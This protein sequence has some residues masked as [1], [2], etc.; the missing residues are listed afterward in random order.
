MKQLRQDAHEMS[1][2]SEL[3]HEPKEEDKGETERT[4]EGDERT[5]LH[6]E[7]NAA[8]QR[9]ASIYKH[10]F[11]VTCKI[12]RPPCASHCPFCDH[13]VKGRDHHCPPL[14]TCIGERNM[15]NFAYVLLCTAVLS[16]YTF[17]HLL[18]Y[19]EARINTLD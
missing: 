7:P 3:E 17:V 18:Y 13:C 15:H 19:Y 6:T 2:R 10:R 1:M 9:V 14:N 16:V 8:G 5:Y 11:C 12:W 4:D